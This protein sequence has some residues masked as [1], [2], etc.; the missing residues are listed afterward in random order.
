MEHEGESPSPQSA[1]VK[2]SPRHEALVTP[3]VNA[4]G[5]K[6]K[7]WQPKPVTAKQEVDEQSASLKTRLN[8]RYPEW[9]N[10][11]TAIR[12]SPSQKARIRS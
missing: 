7:H 1:E 6:A 11:A 8:H 5:E 4:W 3:K 12:Q 9:G 10:K 2:A